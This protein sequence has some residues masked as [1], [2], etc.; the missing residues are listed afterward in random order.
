MRAH[1]G[2]AEMGL[3]DVGECLAPDS[4]RRTSMRPFL[5][6]DRPARMAA[7][8]SVRLRRVCRVD[9]RADTGRLNRASGNPVGDARNASENPRG[10]PKCMTVGVAETHRVLSVAWL[11]HHLGTLPGRKLP[12]AYP[13]YSR[14][15][16]TGQFMNSYRCTPPCRGVNLSAR[17]HA[18]TT[19]W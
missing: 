16:D 17:A 5:R 8:I 7:A 3:D 10:R 1:F 13:K 6:G 4:S 19:L 2:M 18:P 11:R 12:R 9:L 15:C 14:G